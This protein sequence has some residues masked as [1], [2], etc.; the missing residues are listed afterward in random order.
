MS[1]FDPL[2]RIPD[3]PTWRCP[4]CRTLQP[5]SSRCRGCSRAAVSCASCHYFRPSFVGALG[6]CATDPAREP[7]SGHEVRPCWVSLG[8]TSAPD[9]GL[10]DALLSPSSAA[11]A[12]PAPSAPA[13][14]SAFSPVQQPVDVEDDEAHSEHRGRLVEAPHVAPAGTLVSEL[15][16]RSGQDHG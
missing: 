12:L 4:H 3:A 15:Q 8:A 6:F 1:I 10:L 9:G 11:T 5:E 13:G 16:R 2:E 7:L 14:V